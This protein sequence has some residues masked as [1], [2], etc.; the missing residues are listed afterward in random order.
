MQFVLSH[1]HVKI[2]Y[3]TCMFTP[4]LIPPE[5]MNSPFF[6]VRI[7]LSPIYESDVVVNV[8]G[9]EI[10]S[11]RGRRRKVEAPC[12]SSLYFDRTLEAY[13]GNFRG[14]NGGNFWGGDLLNNVFH[15]L[16]YG[17]IGTGT[18]WA[19]ASVALLPANTESLFL[20]P[21]S[22]RWCTHSSPS[23]SDVEAICSSASRVERLEADFVLTSCTHAR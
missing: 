13:C 9:W 21:A 8:N 3:K 1:F 10:D 2:I 17:P 15:G 11:D 14:G 6:I 19:A 23:S 20:M 7:T 16:L 22:L 4:K 5:S 18:A 12:I